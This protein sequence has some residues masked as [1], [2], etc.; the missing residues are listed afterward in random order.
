MDLG[1]EYHKYDGELSNMGKI[2][3]RLRIDVRFGRLIML[4]LVYGVVEE[5]IIIGNSF[6]MDDYSAFRPFN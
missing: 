6:T 5:A 2:I 1:D 4:G 3:A